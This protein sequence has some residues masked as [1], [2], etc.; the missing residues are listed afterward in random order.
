[1]S[2]VSQANRRIHGRRSARVAARLEHADGAVDGMIEN[3]GAGGVFFASEDLEL[4]AE[5]GSA[6]ALEFRL[7]K[8]GADVPM[9]RTGTIL[10][11]ERQFDGEAVV[12][13][14]A[15]RFDEVLAVDGFELS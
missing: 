9:R 8:D 11:V 10:R 2:D 14:Y 12:R 1:M 13:T 4:V 5:D 7:R 3:I 15:I 6:V